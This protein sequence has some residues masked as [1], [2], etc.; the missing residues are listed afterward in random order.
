MKTIRYGLIKLNKDF[1]YTLLNLGT[2]LLRYRNISLFIYM[3][4]LLRPFQQALKKHIIIVCNN[5]K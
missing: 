2:N 5:N 4:Q 1:H 3:S